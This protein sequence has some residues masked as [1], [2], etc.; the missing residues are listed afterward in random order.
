MARCE[1]VRLGEDFPEP[2]AT[3]LDVVVDDKVG[4]LEAAVHRRH[5]EGELVLPARALKPAGRRGGRR[6]GGGGGVTV[7]S[8]H[9]GVW[10]S[11]HHALQE[12][13]HDAAAV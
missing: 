9:A 8:A 1:R 13:G 11:H 10:V 3:H 2:N 6:G 5:A 7:A 4:R 12:Q